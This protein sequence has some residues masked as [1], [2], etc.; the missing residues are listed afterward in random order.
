MTKRT[1]AAKKPTGKSIRD[2]VIEQRKV[3]AEELLANPANWRKH[4]DQQRAAF[5]GLLKEIGFAGSALAYYSE[6]A[7]GAL[8][9]IDG[10]LRRE[11]LGP[12]FELACTI[13]DLTD[14]EADK[15]LA[16]YDPVGA[17]AETDR[18]TFDELLKRAAWDDVAVNAMLA[19][20]AS[21][22]TVDEPV[23]EVT[24]DDVPEPQ[25]VPITKPGD[26]WLLGR[27]RVLCG[28]S[29]KA[30]DVARLMGG[31]AF[32]SVV[33]DPPYGMAFQS[34]H[35]KTQHAEI[36][37]DGDES[38][39][40]LAIGLEATH[41]KYVWCRWDNIPKNPKPKSVITWAK[42]NWSM[43]DLEHEHARQTEVCLFWPGRDHIWPDERPAD[44]VLH[45]R[46][47]NE[48]HPTQKPVTL[49]VEVVGWTSGLIYD[50]FL[51]SGTTLIAAEQ[52][53]RKCYG[54]EISPQYCDVIVKRWENLTGKKATLERRKA[55]RRNASKAS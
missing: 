47:N 38:L 1:K 49:L 46:T 10:H 42:N 36:A 30:D 25:A 52:L 22:A 31:S 16:A 23:R 43:G 39:L 2:R 53:G 3:R 8:T 4:P 21:E 19:Q 15:L 11:E 26:L 40:Q 34:N 32:D 33:C 48:L 44:L 17:L 35:R 55:S 45:A 28:D 20:V 7:G 50:P 12:R 29:K 27:H 14:A 13:T 54:M 37:G 41:S 9:L 51:G 5:R 24:E 18:A 6:R